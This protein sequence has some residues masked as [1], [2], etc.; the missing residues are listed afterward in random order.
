MIVSCGSCGMAVKNND[1]LKFYHNPIIHNHQLLTSFTHSQPPSSS[2]FIGLPFR[3]HSSKQGCSGG[4]VEGRP[5][6]WC[7]LGVICA[8]KYRLVLR[9]D[10]EGICIRMTSNCGL[11][12]RTTYLRCRSYITPGQSDNGRACDVAHPVPVLSSSTHVW[13][14]SRKDHTLTRLSQLT[15]SNR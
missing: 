14:S 10:K 11:P 3:R 15:L 12:L 8:N 6:P 5:D 2:F 9:A 13:V 4:R 7:G 1:F